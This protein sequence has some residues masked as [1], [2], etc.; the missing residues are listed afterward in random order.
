M[1]NKIDQQSIQLDRWN[2]IQSKYKTENLSRFL[3]KMFLFLEKQPYGICIPA[4]YNYID[5]SYMNCIPSDSIENKILLIEE[6]ISNMTSTNKDRFKYIFYRPF[7]Y[8]TR[9]QIIW[10]IHYENEVIKN[11]YKILNK[12]HNF[13]EYGMSKEEADKAYFMLRFKTYIHLQEDK[14][15]V[16]KFNSYKKE[17]KAKSLVWN[18]Q[19]ENSEGECMNPYGHFLYFA[20]MKTEYF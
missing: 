13:S 20:N 3:D 18:I 19:H 10:Y 1:F 9:D 16:D 5:D 12:L 11:R 7:L 15:S 4:T 6:Y 17:F 8:N 14:E 2:G